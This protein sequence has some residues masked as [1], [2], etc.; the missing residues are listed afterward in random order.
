[1]KWIAW[2][3]TVEKFSIPPRTPYDKIVVPTQ[4]SIRMMSI[5]RKL[6]EQEVYPIIGY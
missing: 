1:M 6:C 2:E 5:T 3:D 4:D